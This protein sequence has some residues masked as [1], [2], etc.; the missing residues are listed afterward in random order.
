V[1]ELG[2]TAVFPLLAA[3]L[4]AALPVPLWLGLR[5]RRTA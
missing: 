4:L 1:Q 2:I 3:F 5:T